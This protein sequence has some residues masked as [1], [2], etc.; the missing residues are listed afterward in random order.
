MT[1]FKTLDSIGDIK[2]KRV[3]CRVDLNVPVAEG[4]VTDATRIERVAPTHPEL[5]DKGA[6]VDPA[7]AFR[8]PEG[9]ARPEHSLKPIAEA[10][11]GVIG[12]PVGFATDCIGQ[13]AETASAGDAGRRHPAPGEH[14]L[15]P[16]RGEERSATSSQALA[17]LGDIYVNDAFSAAHRAHASTEGMARGSAGLCRAHHA[18]GARGTGQ[19]ARATPSSAGRHRRRGQDLDQDRPAHQ[20]DQRRSMRWSSAAAWP[21]PSSPRAAPRRQLAREHDLAATAQADHDR[22]QRS[23]AAPSCCRRTP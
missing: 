11:A 15:S 6:R 2:G 17:K 16:G 3:L 22:R 21:T 5:A 1:A 19:G 20:S 10:A 4:K 13:A 7:G 18:G 8:S 12:R 9:R 23:P 14:P